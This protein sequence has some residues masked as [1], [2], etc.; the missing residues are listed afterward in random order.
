MNTRVVIFIIGGLLFGAILTGLLYYINAHKKVSVP[1]D[2]ELTEYPSP[3]PSPIALQTYE[4][5][6]G[7]SFDYPKTVE[8]NEDKKDTTSYAN[9]LVTSPEFPGSIS[10]QATDTKLKSAEAWFTQNKIDTGD[11]EEI[12][13]GDIEATQVTTS[14]G[15]VTAS[16]DQGALF[17]IHVNWKDQEVFW[18]KVYSTLV[19]TFQFTTPEE[20][21]APAPASSGGSTGDDIIFEGEEIIE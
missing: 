20:D 11:A 9:L 10:F 3:T 8:I 18:Q 16:Y 15:I 12:P 19:S 14:G 2:Q 6:A 21:T 7:F 13:F 1:T 5:E 4:S 17:T